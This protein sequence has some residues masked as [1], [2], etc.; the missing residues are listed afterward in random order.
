MTQKLGRHGIAV[1]AARNG[2]LATL[3]ADLP[4]AILADMLGI[5]VNTAVRWVIYARRDWID[6]LADRAE[7]QLK[8]RQ[9]DS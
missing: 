1:R 8:G 4:V 2:A 6:Y 5:H 9:T 7:E 3:A